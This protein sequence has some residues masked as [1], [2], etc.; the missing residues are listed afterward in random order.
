MERDIRTTG[1][2]REIQEFC[3][4]VR[5]PGTKQISDAAQVQASPDGRHVVFAGTVAERIEE[6]P[7]T[8][9]A[10]TEL[11]TGMTRLL[12]SGPNTDKFPSFSPDGRRIAFLSDRHRAGHF[13]LYILDAASGAV[14]ETRRVDG[15]VEHLQWAADGTRILLRAVGS[16][17]EHSGPR[18]SA[19][20]GARVTAVPSWM[21]RVDATE[22]DPQKRGCWIYAVASDQAY[23]VSA[24]DCNTWEAAWCGEDTL[25]VVASPRSGEGDW[26]SANLC[27]IDVKAGKHHRIYQPADQL[28]PPVVSPTGKTIAIIEGLCS[29]RGPV[30]GDLWLIDPTTG[31]SRKA[32]TH[33]VDAAYVEWYS[34]QHLLVSGQ[35]GFEAV[36]GIYDATSGRFSATWSS[37]DVAVTKLGLAGLKTP[38]DCVILT[39]SFTQAP[40]LTVLRD[41]QCRRITSFDVGYSEATR[42]IAA[43]ERVTWSSV[44]DLEIQGW[45]LRP[46]GS[47]Q[48][49]LIMDVHGGPVGQWKPAFMIRRM[50]H[51]PILLNHGFAVF[52]PNPRGSSGRGQEFARR[53]MG[54]LGGAD[55]QDLLQGLDVLI[56]R[57]V[58]DPARM[59]VTG[60]SYGG[61][62]AAWLITQCAR[63]AAA[64]TVSPHTNQVT[65]QLLSNIPQFMARLVADD[66]S[67]GRGRYFERSPVL[68]AGR[69]TTPT[70]NICGALDRCTPAEEAVQF[71][72]ALLQNG[73]Q[74]VLVTYPQEGHG[75]RRLP[76][77]LDCATRVT[78][79]FLEHIPAAANPG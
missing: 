44:D 49:P 73:T 67:N 34:E 12:T 3:R 64:V 4:D 62:M 51:I 68:H 32:D 75:I 35:R 31:G 54:D 38:G 14:S 69:A 61:F 36:V 79:W 59:G 57:G 15:S 2:Y 42:S 47:Q 33:G 53:V 48:H 52:L 37:Q 22:A 40:E 18:D 21:P 1:L 56:E 10:L 7:P 27:I 74:S 6:E 60:A 66:M 41:G 9:I 20:L 29:D 46:H 23:P 25:A 26:Y 77:M 45:V 43:V 58:A 70:L 30:V 8:R 65:A 55:S 5:Q 24:G 16:D 11:A 39:E 17:T 50:L 76:A 28:G 78:A 72:N 71:H 19:G 63:F 13:Q